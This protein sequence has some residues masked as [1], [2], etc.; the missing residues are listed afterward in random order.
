MGK[1]LWWIIERKRCDYEF[2]PPSSNEVYLIRMV[3]NDCK[4]MNRNEWKWKKKEEN[5]WKRMGGD[6]VY[7]YKKLS[8]VDFIR[9]FLLTII[10]NV[11]LTVSLKKW[12]C[13]VTWNYGS[14]CANQFWLKSLPLIVLIFNW[15]LYSWKSNTMVYPLRWFLCYLSRLR[16]MMIIRRSHPYLFFLS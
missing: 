15:E 14:Q 7:K 4:R 3:E 9:I 1:L 10:S 5:E 2:K 13:M 11:V 16:R 6:Y 8:S 12:F